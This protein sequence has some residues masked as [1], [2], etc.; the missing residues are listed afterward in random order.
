RP[1][2]QAFRA[3]GIPYQVIGGVAFYERREV[4]DVLAYLSLMINPKDDMAFSRVV[5]IP[6]RG[7]GATSVDHLV[8]AARERGIP[9][10]AMAR[11]ARSVS[12]LKEKALRGLDRFTGL[13]DELAE[14]RRESAEEVLRQVVDRAGYREHL[15]A[16]SRDGGDERVANVDE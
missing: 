5:N 9:V 2:E 3:A 14:L 11:E 13:L 8:I 10:L 15:M 7:V 16:E 1:F 4:K 12:E 6:A